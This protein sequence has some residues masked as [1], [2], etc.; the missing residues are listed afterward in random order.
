MRKTDEL[1]PVGKCCPLGFAHPGTSM[2][3]ESIDMG[4]F[5][6]FPISTHAVPVLEEMVKKLGMSKRFPA[7][8]T[9]LGNLL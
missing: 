2:M 7:F 4:F 9:F 8:R 1:D 6:I 5:F 3:T